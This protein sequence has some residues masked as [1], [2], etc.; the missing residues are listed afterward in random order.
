MARYKSVGQMV[1]AGDYEALKEF[2]TTT[3][4]SVL[5]AIKEVNEKGTRDI[6]SLLQFAIAAKGER[7][8]DIVELLIK[9]GANINMTDKNGATLLM[10]AAQNNNLET[11]RFLMQNPNIELNK[12]DEI[13][14]KATHY[15]VMGNAVEAFDLLYQTGQFDINE[16]TMLAEETYLHFATQQ[17][18]VEIAYRLMELGIDPTVEN[19]VEGSLAAAY[20][21][22]VEDNEDGSPGADAD[23]YNKLFEDLEN[24]REKFKKSNNAFDF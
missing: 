22:E 4:T 23:K 6:D 13:F 16:K 7:Q 19:A 15:A 20:V 12:I 5:N 9:Y 18:S 3:E 24:Y 14:K 21:P 11:M 1:K 2:F 10:V 17:G 8:L